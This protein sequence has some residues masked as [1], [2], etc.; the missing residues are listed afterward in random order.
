MSPKLLK[1]YNTSEAIVS[2]SKLGV[3]EG[4]AH[5]YMS[6]PAAPEALQG[7][8]ERIWLGTGPGRNPRPSGRPGPVQDVLEPA[9]G[10]HYARNPGGLSLQ[11]GS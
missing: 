6:N 7:P 2:I 11:G 5:S 10:E 4:N 9:R 8:Q 1:T 3:M